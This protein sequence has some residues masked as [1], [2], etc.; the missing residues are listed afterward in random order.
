MIQNYNLFMAICVCT[1]NVGRVQNSCT[2]QLLPVLAA[3]QG[4]GAHSARLAGPQGRYPSV[5]FQPR[6]T[7][8]HQKRN[9]PVTRCAPVC[10]AV[11]ER[12]DPTV[13]SDFF[14]LEPP[15]AHLLARPHDNHGMPSIGR[16]NAQS[17]PATIAFATDATATTA[18]LASHDHNHPLPSKPPA[19][20][21]R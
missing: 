16:R 11:C 8:A 12:S 3:N 15:T 13:E 20:T 21:A 1:G 17:Y 5:Q 4:R 14:K 19:E 10:P 9:P 7:T 18:S 2:A 6:P